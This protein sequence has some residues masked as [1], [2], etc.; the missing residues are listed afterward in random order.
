M[1]TSASLIVR[2]EFCQE[3]ENAGGLQFILDVFTN[4]P[5]VEKINWQ[6]LK[7]LKTLAGNDDVKA[8]IITSGIAPLIVYAISRFRVCICI[9]QEKFK[10]K[11]KKVSVQISH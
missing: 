10:K 1:L 4:Y 7:L 9:M 11:N 3:F 6:A 5:D 8:H 2:N